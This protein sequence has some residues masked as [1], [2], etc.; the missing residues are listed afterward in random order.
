MRQ[1]ITD[2][3]VSEIIGT[4]LML[5]IVVGV[6]TLLYVGVMSYD[7]NENAIP[8]KIVGSIEGTNIVFEHKGGRDVGLESML[9]VSVGDIKNSVFRSWNN[10]LVCF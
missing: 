1:N 9:V 7:F 3:A 8:V 4:I 6:F 2:N 5:A 10:H